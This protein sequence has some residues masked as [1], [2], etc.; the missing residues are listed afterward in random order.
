[1]AKKG[2]KICHAVTLELDG[3]GRCANCA[4]AKEATDSGTSYGKYMAQ[5]AVQPV[6][7]RLPKN[8]VV[9]VNCG[10]PFIVL[11]GWRLYCDEECRRNAAYKRA[12]ARAAER[13]AANG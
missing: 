12:K 7:R 2:C 6:V 3:T 13:E 1:M 10:R 8:T 5:M 4:A 11:K 9:C